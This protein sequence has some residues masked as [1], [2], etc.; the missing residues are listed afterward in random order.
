MQSHPEYSEIMNQTLHNFFVNSSNVPVISVSCHDNLMNRDLANWW[1]FV[2]SNEIRAFPLDPVLGKSCCVSRCAILLKDEVVP[3]L[4]DTWPES[5]SVNAVSLAKKI[6]KIPEISNIFPRGLLFWR[7]LYIGTKTSRQCTRYSTR[8]LDCTNARHILVCNVRNTQSRPLYL[9]MMRP[10]LAALIVCAA[11]LA[12]LWQHCH[13]VHAVEHFQ[14][15]WTDLCLAYFRDLHAT[16]LSQ[17]LCLNFQDTV[18]WG[19]WG[20]CPQD[21]IIWCFISWKAPE[22]RCY[23]RRDF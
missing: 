20:T 17:H 21:S 15:H 6:T 14:E 10:P 12:G 22:N 3:N 7:A 23:Q 4:Q 13:F 1:S 18:H 11:S 9:A 2:F 16:M 19:T 5:S 8:K